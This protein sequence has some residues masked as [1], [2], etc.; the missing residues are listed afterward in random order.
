[1]AFGARG[2]GFD[3]SLTGGFNVGGGDFSRYSIGDDGSNV[4]YLAKYSASIAWNN[5]AISDDEYLDALLKYWRSHD[6]GSKEWIAAKNEYEDTVYTI[7]RNKLVMKVN[8]AASIGEHTRA[9]QSLLAYERNRMSGMNRDNEQFREMQERISDIEAKLRGDRWSQAVE[10]FNAGR[11]SLAEM[12]TVARRLAA[13]SR[14]SPDHD[15]YVGHVRDFGERI[16]NDALSTL[17]DQWQK[18]KV[19][20]G[21]VL[22]QIDRMMQ[23]LDRDSPRYKEL[24][25]SREGFIDS[26]NNRQWADEDAR[27]TSP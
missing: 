13:A 8:E 7:G 11:M 2:G 17:F 25:K 1:M 10:R 24:A 22:S 5:G 19:G 23:G 14:G 20:R 18:R 3:T 4:A 12:Q 21:A 9:L 6:K 26:A 16:D 15:T 27:I